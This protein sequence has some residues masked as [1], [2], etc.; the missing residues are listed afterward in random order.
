MADSVMLYKYVCKNVAARHGKVVTFMPKPLF[1]DNGSGMHIHFSL[2]K[3]QKNL[4]AGNRY[5]GL[6]ETGLFAIGGILKHASRL[7][8]PLQ[9]DDQQLQAARP[10]LRSPRESCLQ[11]PQPVGG[12]PHSDVQREAADQAHRVPLP[13]LQLQ[14]VSGL[15]QH[16]D[17]RHRRDHQQDP[18]RRPDG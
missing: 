5:A 16:A 10:R 4:F 11:Q 8:A 2:W 12:D 14:P 18:S 17:G 3:G 7:C 1:Q 6:S 15:Q 13:R 9:P